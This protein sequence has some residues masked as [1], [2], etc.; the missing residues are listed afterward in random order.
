MADDRRG[1][2]RADAVRRAAAQPGH[3]RAVALAIRGLTSV[4][5]AS[6]TGIG[7]WIYTIDLHHFIM[8]GLGCLVF[9][10]VFA[11]ARRIGQPALTPPRRP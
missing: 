7:V 4:L 1:R 3:R 6:S 10:L 11:A 9:A 8:S 2:G 5:I